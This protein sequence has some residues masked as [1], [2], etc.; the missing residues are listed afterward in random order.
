MKCDNVRFQ[1]QLYN[2]AVVQSLVRNVGSNLQKWVTMTTAL[3]SCSPWSF[4]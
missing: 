2:M 3:Q 1:P 4:R